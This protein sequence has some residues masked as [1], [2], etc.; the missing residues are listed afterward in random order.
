MKTVA[1]LRVSTGS[2]G[3]PAGV[4]QFP[5][6]DRGSN[7]DRTNP[8]AGMPALSENPTEYHLLTLSITY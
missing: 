8:P 7:R 3:V 2:A 1:N 4:L 6:S 5:T